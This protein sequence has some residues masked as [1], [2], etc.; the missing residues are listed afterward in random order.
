MGGDEREG[1]QVTF[2]SAI[3]ERDALFYKI[4]SSDGSIGRLLFIG[5]GLKNKRQS[6]SGMT[7]LQI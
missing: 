3:A 7:K 4:P 5:K 6:R 2:C 1:G